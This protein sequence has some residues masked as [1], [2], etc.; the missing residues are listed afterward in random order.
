MIRKANLSD[1]DVIWKIISAAAQNLFDKFGTRHWLD[2]YTEE[3]IVKKLKTMPTYVYEENGEV[4][5]VY[6]LSEELPSY[7]F[8][9]ETFDYVPNPKSVYLNMLGVHPNTQGKGIGS[10]LVEHS[11][12]MSKEL[13]Y[14]WMIFDTKAEITPIVEFYKK[15][16]FKIVADLI[17]EGDKYFFFEKSL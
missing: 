2:W 7:L 13:G 3:L 11:Q 17:D 4:L 9:D 5:G 1:K 12:Q 8:V 15:L 14:Q 16:R 10:K 6:A